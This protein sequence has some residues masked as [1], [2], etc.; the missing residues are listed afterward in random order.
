MTVTQVD[1]NTTAKYG[2]THKITVSYTDIQTA[3]T[4]KT[5]AIFPDPTSSTST[6]VGLS[7][8]VLSINVTTAFAGTSITALT[9]AIGDGN[10]TDRLCTTACQDADLLTAAGTS[11]LGRFITAPY[12]YNS[13]D[14][15]DA[16]FTATGA[17]TSALTAGSVDIYVRAVARN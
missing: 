2:H 7:V 1:L 16:L 3:A 10:D 6:L 9:L 8:A 14:T 13:A 4:T 5:L 11:V 15:V 12:T 17:N